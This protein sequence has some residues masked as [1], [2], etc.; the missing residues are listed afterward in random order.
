VFVC[1]EAQVSTTP[2]L[3]GLINGLSSLID[4]GLSSCFSGFGYGTSCNNPTVIANTTAATSRYVPVVGS[5]AAIVADLDLLLTG[6]RL[7]TTL[8]AFIAAEYDNTLRT[9]NN[10]V[11][12]LKYAQKMILLSTE[13]HTNNA[14]LLSST[15]R[16]VAA[17]PPS[18]NRPSKN[19]IV[20]FL[21][22]GLDSYNLLL[23]DPSCALYN[24]VLVHVD[25]V[26]FCD[27][28]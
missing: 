11:T 18:L 4:N 22:G 12:A 16:P 28:S 26:A 23:P 8:K 21:N 6:G 19:V 24:E 7:N 27:V 9:T 10:S 25:S 14:N 17:A 15:V 2:P 13:F 20:I 3:I 1:T 5:S